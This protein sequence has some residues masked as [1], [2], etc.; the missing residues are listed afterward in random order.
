MEEWTQWRLAAKLLPAAALTL[1][2]R[3]PGH[4]V[5]D[6]GRRARAEPQRAKRRGSTA[7]Q[8][9]WRRT[10]ARGAGGGERGEGAR[11]GAAAA[12]GK[13]TTA[14]GGKGR[15]R[16]G[17][18]V[19]RPP[20]SGSPNLLSAPVLRPPSSSSPNLPLHSGAPASSSPN[21]LSA[22]ASGSATRASAL[23]CRSV[24]Q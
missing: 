8:R 6:D 13:G 1:A 3:R 11:R 19:L 22:P 16:E 18:P 17:A 7:S 10:R 12:A 14:Q 20:V 4:D 21:L 5:S 9:G 23:V 15:G 24:R 2:A